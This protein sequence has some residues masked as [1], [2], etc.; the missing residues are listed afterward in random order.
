MVCGCGVDGYGAVIVAV[1][2]WLVDFQR[3]DRMFMC[4]AEFCALWRDW[5]YC[6]RVFGC[7]CLILAALMIL[8]CVIVWSM[9]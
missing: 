4:L 6:V 8:C 2:L 3:D 9:R 7:A 1:G 5:C